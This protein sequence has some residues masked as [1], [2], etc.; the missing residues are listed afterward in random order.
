MKQIESNSIKSN[1]TSKELKSKRMNNKPRGINLRV[2]GRIIIEGGRG[3]D[4]GA[5]NRGRSENKGRVVGEALSRGNGG[6]RQGKATFLGGVGIKSGGGG[7]T[8]IAAGTWGIPEGVVEALVG[9]IIGPGWLL[10]LGSVG[11]DEVK[12]KNAGG[13][14]VVV[15]VAVIVIVIFYY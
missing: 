1:L 11:L 14:M 2:T 6:A 7:G 15:V 3:A 5:G 9:L 13:A 4:A 10:G 8:E 12:V